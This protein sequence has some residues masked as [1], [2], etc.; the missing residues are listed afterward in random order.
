M[1]EVNAKQSNHFFNC[2]C[3]TGQA[4]GLGAAGH[5]GG[6]TLADSWTGSFRKVQGPLI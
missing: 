3:P 2:V 1:L 6:Q 5:F 4:E